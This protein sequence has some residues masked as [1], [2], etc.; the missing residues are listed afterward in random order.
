MPFR[1][2]VKHPDGRMTDRLV[3][4]SLAEAETHYTH[5]CETRTPGPASAIFEPPVRELESRR[6]R[7]DENYPDDCR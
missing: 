6:H 2:Y 1:V 3:T 5:L 4:G 7:L